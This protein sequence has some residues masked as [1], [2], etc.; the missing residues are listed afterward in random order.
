[1]TP[2]KASKKQNDMTVFINLYPVKRK[3]RPPVKFAFGDKVRIHKKKGFFEKGYMPN[4][5]EEV[6]IIQKYSK[7]I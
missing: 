4:W 3:K 6:F 5:T 2:V 1:M 7:Q